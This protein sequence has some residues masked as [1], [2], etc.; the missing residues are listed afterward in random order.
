LGR[1]I[2]LPPLAA[3][4]PNPRLSEIDKRVSAIDIAETNIPAED[5]RMPARQKSI[6][7]VRVVKPRAPM[8]VSPE[9]VRAKDAFSSI[10]VSLVDDESIPWIPLAPYSDHI[11][12]KYFRLDPA[13]GEMIMLFRASSLE[14]LPRCHHSGSTIVY[15]VTGRWTQLEEDWI[16][17]PGSLVHIPAATARTAS[18]FGEGESVVALVVVRGDIIFYKDNGDVLA[19][20]NWR[21]AMDR[22]LAYCD[23]AFI[24]PVDLTAMT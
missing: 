7:P 24:T 15:T 5:R 3:Y 4:R 17:G 22:Y 21:T 23:H 20:E 11:Q 1:R 12:V 10:G 19:I 18:V 14:R 8:R 6:K 9:P 2:L 16:A 13:R